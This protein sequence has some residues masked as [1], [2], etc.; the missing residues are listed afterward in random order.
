MHYMHAKT[1][2]AR[3]LAMLLLRHVGYTLHCI[4]LYKW[5]VL[6]GRHGFTAL[7]CSILQSGTAVR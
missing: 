4:R 2:I 1:N 5:Q 6:I 3:T 7:V